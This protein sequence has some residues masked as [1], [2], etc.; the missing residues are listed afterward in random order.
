MNKR[1]HIYRLRKI[2]SSH[3]SQDGNSIRRTHLGPQQQ[4]W[5]AVPQGHHHGGVGLQR[6]S[7][8][9]RQAKVTNLAT[10]ETHKYSRYKTF[11]CFS[12]INIH[13]ACKMLL[14]YAGV[15]AESKGTWMKDTNKSKVWNNCLSIFPSIVR[16][17]C[18]GERNACAWW[19]PHLEDALVAEQQVGRLQVAVEDPVVV[20]MSDPSQQLNHQGLHL[21][22]R[23]RGRERAR[24][25]TIAR[26]IL[27]SWSL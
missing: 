13:R 20:E 25:R 1:K 10:R 23:G 7:V 21:T 2:H 3:W 15:T 9:P 11:T 8:L 14:Y 4:L 12:D 6:R 27:M 24:A 26:E 19:S 22:C 17:W 18:Y 5:G 16:L